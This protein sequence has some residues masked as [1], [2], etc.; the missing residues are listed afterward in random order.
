MTSQPE[1]RF[2]LTEHEALLLESIRAK[3]PMVMVP[4]QQRY[5]QNDYG[6][7][8]GG[9]AARDLER[10]DWLGLNDSFWHFL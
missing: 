4:F 1:E 7:H 8:E 9:W 10:Q 5:L 6:S 3:E 2:P